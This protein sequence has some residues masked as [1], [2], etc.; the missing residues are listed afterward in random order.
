[1]RLGLFFTSAG[2]KNDSKVMAHQHPLATRV[3]ELEKQ[4]RDA[5]D[6][7]QALQKDVESLCLNQG[8]GSKSFQH[9]HVLAQRVAAS[10]TELKETRAKVCNVR[11]PG[12]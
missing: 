1:M 5:Q 4:L 12:T 2:R 10:D 3:K 11:L 8:L 6:E 9:S 7:N